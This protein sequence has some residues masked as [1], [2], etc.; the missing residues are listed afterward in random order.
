VA[1][2]RIR[3]IFADAASSQCRY[4]SGS[5]IARG[6]SYPR[7]LPIELVRWYVYVRDI[8]HTI[9]CRMKH[10]ALLEGKDGTGNMI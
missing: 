4:H 10:L 1:T 3:L 5:S 8:G 2:C 6:H 9:V 7:P